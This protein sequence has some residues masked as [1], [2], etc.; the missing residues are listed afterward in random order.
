MTR[1]P[2]AKPQKKTGSLPQKPTTVCSSPV[3]GRGSPSNY[4]SLKNNKSLGFGFF[5]YNVLVFF[6]V[7]QYFRRLERRLSAVKNTS[8]SPR[9]SRFNFQQLHRGSQLV[10]GD[11][12]APCLSRHQKLVVADVHASKTPINKLF[13]KGQCFNIYVKFLN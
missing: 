3:K 11:A 2:S 10:V 1:L 8:N 9:G 4:T 6:R 7:S 5:V 13:L 12:S